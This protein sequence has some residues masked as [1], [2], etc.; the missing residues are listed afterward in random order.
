VEE[1]LSLTIKI[2]QHN[3]APLVR[4][5]GR[6]LDVD[7][8]KF[9]R[10]MEWANRKS[11]KMIIV[12]ISNVEYLDSHGLGVL[13]YYHSLLEREQRK[14]F[15]LNSNTDMSSYVYRLFDLTNLRRVL[16]FRNSLESIEKEM[17]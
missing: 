15:L 17:T 1:F 10:K 5:E 12:D 14:L 3:D 13:V 6:I 4:A 8:R 2:I 11:P 16:H 7:V 9:S